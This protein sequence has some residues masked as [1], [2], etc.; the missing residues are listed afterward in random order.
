MTAGTRYSF[1]GH[2]TLPREVLPG[3]YIS[4]ADPQANKF[5]QILY[6]G[7]KPVLRDLGPF[8][9]ASLRQFVDRRTFAQVR[10]SRTPNRALASLCEAHR[11]IVEA[12]AIGRGKN[13]A[14]LAS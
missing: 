1:G 13:F 8:R 5:E 7:P 2:V 12:A 4:F 10:R 3:G 11:T 14:R 6:L 9:G